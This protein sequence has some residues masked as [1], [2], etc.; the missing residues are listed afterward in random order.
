LSVSLLGWDLLVLLFGSLV[1]SLFLFFLIVGRGFVFIIINHFFLVL[2][3][4]VLL[5]LLTLLVRSWSTDALDLS[6]QIVNFV[7]EPNSILLEVYGEHEGSKEW[8]SEDE[9]S[10]GGR[11]EAIG[12]DDG[13]EVIGTLIIDLEQKETAFFIEVFG[14]ENRGNLELEGVIDSDGDV[15]EVVVRTRLLAQNVGAVGTH[16]GVDSVHLQHQRVE[17]V[18]RH[19]YRVLSSGQHA[20]LPHQLIGSLVL[21]TGERRC[22]VD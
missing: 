12:S 19:H 20:S 3:F 4:L 18:G 5:L 9:A 16:V 17:L 15:V 7:G 10:I 2:F 11:V 13:V 1:G 21:L 8:E 6:A 14:V 22:T